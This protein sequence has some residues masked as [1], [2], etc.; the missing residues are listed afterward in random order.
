MQDVYG[1]L[2]TEF[3]KSR[4]LARCGKPGYAQHADFPKALPEDLSLSWI[5]TQGLQVR[6]YPQF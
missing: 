5:A 4:Y 6:P 1:V 2:A 3:P